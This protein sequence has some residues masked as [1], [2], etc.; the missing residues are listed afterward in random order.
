MYKVMCHL[1]AVLSSYGYK[2]TVI[3][4]AIVSN[5]YNVYRCLPHN[6]IEIKARRV[7]FI[8]ISSYK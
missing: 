4:H 8:N 3:L 1:H 2:R 6:G 5:L 7:I